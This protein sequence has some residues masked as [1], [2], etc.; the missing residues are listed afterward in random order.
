MFNSDM[1]CR[2]CNNVNCHNSGI[3]EEGKTIDAVSQKQVEV[4]LIE[5]LVEKSLEQIQKIGFSTTRIAPKKANGIIRVYRHCALEHDFEK[6][7][8]YGVNLFLKCGKGFTDENGYTIDYSKYQF[9]WWFCQDEY[10]I[11]EPHF[12]DYFV[13]IR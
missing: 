2:L 10:A 5:D 4:P 13:L 9:R 11:M 8:M 7:W 1:R 6:F 12:V 3:V